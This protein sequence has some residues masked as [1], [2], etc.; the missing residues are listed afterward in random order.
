[1]EIVSS[2]P[3]GRDSKKNFVKKF[4]RPQI[5]I[6]LTL[7]VHQK[8]GILCFGFNDDR[9]H[10]EVHA[11]YQWK[12]LKKYHNLKVMLWNARINRQG[13][14][15]LSQPCFHC[16]QYIRR[17]LLFFHQ[18]GFTTGQDQQ[19]I[20]SRDEYLVYPFHEHVSRGHLLYSTILSKKKKRRKQY[21]DNQ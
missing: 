3:S 13:V 12:N 8:Y 7:I 16:S 6:H 10:S 4:Q 11:L 15:C 9:I 17:N 14:L 1:M 19:S 2:R 18:I 21:L 20:L 5:H